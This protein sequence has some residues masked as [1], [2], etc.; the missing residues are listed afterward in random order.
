MKD[1]EDFKECCDNCNVYPCI[2][3]VNLDKMDDN[4]DHEVYGWAKRITRKVGCIV[5]KTMVGKQS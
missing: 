2:S 3:L 1:S 5:N 4:N